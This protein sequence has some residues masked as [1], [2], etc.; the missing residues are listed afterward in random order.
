M[1]AG[2]CVIDPSSDALIERLCLLC[3]FLGSVIRA[4]FSPAFSLQ[5]TRGAAVFLDAVSSPPLSAPGL[6]NLYGKVLVALPAS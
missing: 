5:S 4:A 1:L 3:E 6:S 2:H